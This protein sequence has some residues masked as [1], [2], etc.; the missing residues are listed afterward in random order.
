MACT[1]AA[2]A[3][4]VSAKITAPCGWDG[5][6][7]PGGAQGPEPGAGSAGPGAAQRCR[8]I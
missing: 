1:V 8:L 2:R 6:G 3:T 7:A 5:A 4:M